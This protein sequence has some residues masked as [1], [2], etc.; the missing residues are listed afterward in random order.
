MNDLTSMRR[1]LIGVIAVVLLSGA[2]WFQIWPPMGATAEGLQ[3]ACWRVGALMTVLWLAYPEVVR[4]PAWLVGTIPVLGLILALKPRWLL[5]AV[6]IVIALAIL[7]P[8]PP[9]K[10]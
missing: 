9:K 1:H 10:K 2:V 3:A 8:K 6:P 5:I 7:K 4:L